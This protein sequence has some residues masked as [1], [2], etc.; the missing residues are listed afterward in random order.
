M[1]T[2]QVANQPSFN[3][4][5]YFGKQT[6]Q[7]RRT[8]IINVPSDQLAKNGLTLPQ[9]KSPRSSIDGDRRSIPDNEPSLTDAETMS[10]ASNSPSEISNEWSDKIMPSFATKTVDA[11]QSV[12]VVL[13][14]TGS[15][16]LLH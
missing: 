1:V 9:K 15:E 3:T 10:N 2:G 5:R 14:D 11:D 8:R 12:E 16:Q 4:T 13:E 6:D 7:V